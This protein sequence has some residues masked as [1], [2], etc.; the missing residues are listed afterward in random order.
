[1]EASGSLVSDRFLQFQFVGRWGLVQEDFEESGFGFGRRDNPDGDLLEYDARA[2]LFPAGK[3][4]LNTFAR[5]RQERIPRPFLP[6]IEFDRQVEGVE[7]LYNDPVLP[8]RLTFE[9]EFEDRTSIGR[10][11]LDDEIY[12]DKRLTYD[13]TWRPSDT[14]RL[15]LNYEYSDQRQRFAGSRT[16]FDTARSDLTLSHELRFGADERSSFQTFG[17]FQDEVGDLARDIYEVSPQLILQHTDSFATHYRFQYYQD[18]FEGTQISQWRGEAGFTHQ[19]NDALLTTAN[20]YFLRQDAERFGDTDEWGG[21]INFAYAREN[22]LGSFRGNLN[23]TH[24]TIE[25]EADERVGQVINETVTFRD[26]L[27]AYLQNADIDRLSIRITDLERQ[28]VYVE[29]TDYVVITFGRFTQLRRVLNG[30]IQNGQA[31]RVTYRFNRSP[32]LMLDRDRVDLR[33]QQDFKNGWTPY[34]YGSYQFESVDGNFGFTP[35]RDINRHRLGVRYQRPRGSVGAEYE[36]NDDSIDPYQAAHFTGDVVLL[37]RSPHTLDGRSNFSYF[38]FR[39]APGLAPRDTLLFDAGVGYRCLLG[40]RSECRFQALYRY[41][42]DSI[43]GATHGFDLNG[44]IFWQ[45]GLFTAS[46]E[47]EYDRLDLPGSND[48]TFAAWFRLRREIPVIRR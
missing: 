23:Y 24:A 20:L 45:I 10:G 32:R 39:G 28:R 43:F 13:A 22:A 31:V 25:T 7:L 41:E 9:N 14:Q 44:G 4:T 19:A 6:S 33:L 46:V 40:D 35:A 42:D 26:P 15:N 47:L 21:T 8:M 48:E 2:T 29:G 37:N 12:S 36:Y 11:R 27:S 3:L 17:R 38:D 16:R 1:M 5:R 30:R 18:A 34:Y